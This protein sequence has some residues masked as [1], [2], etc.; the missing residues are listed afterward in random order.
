MRNPRILRKKQRLDYLFQQ[1][2]AL[3]DNPELSSEWSRY[4]CVLVSGFIET[5]V[6]TIFSEYAEC[7]SHPHVAN[8]VNKGL[9]RLQN[10]SMGRIL[11]LAQSFSLQ[12]R[13]DL[14]NATDYEMK[15]AVDSIVTNRNKIAHGEDVG[16]S[17]V[18][19]H[20]YY[21]DAVRMLEILE[22]QC[23]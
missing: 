8:Y 15:D 7:R 20:R 23:S 17:Y 18:T 11:D 22:G 19:V 12:L 21:R 10:P 1:V 6:R 5:S 2:S 13:E 16:I 9:D 4:L 14:D 3:P